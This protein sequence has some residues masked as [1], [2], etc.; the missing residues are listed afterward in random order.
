MNK[1]FILVVEDDRFQQMIIT[2]MVKKLVDLPVECVPDGLEALETVKKQ[3]PSLIICDLHM[4]KMDGV[5]FIYELSKQN[6]YPSICILSS[7]DLNIQSAVIEMANCYGIKHMV[8][9]KKPLTMEKLDS[10]IAALN[11]ESLHN[12]VVGNSSA[13]QF[14]KQEIT[15]A[16]ESGAIQ[17]YFQP[18]VEAGAGE[19]VS[20]EALVR[21][22]HPEYGLLTPFHFLNQVSEQ[23]MDYAV[24]QSMCNSALKF[25][26]TVRGLGGK[27][28]VS[29]NATPDDLMQEGLLEFILG[30]LSEYSLP[31]EY[32]T[33]EITETQA[34][35]EIGRLLHIA[36]KLRINGIQ[37]AIDDFGT[38][39]S[40]LSQLISSP[41]TE[42]K[43]DLSFVR[44]MLRS[45]KHSV[46]VRAST[47]IAKELGL[48]IV[49]E[50]V[51][52]KQQ[53]DYLSGLGCDLLQGYYY[54]K[55]VSS[56]SLIQLLRLDITS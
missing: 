8:S 48:K 28:T 35:T 12:K 41:F 31:A 21:W 13:Y 22:N 5:D 46:A 52:T 42:L 32:L 56:K 17:A 11:V 15:L 19:I 37:L 6:T 9:L 4:P 51:E 16:I 24:F 43:I 38:G 36:T 23:Q 30:M 47:L 7:M 53:A 10:A 44:E 18:Q 25:A 34:A 33:I 20:A 27:I 49:A 3:V 55:P 2:S 39:S 40:S 50:G 1:P 54:S 26:A 45:D 29:V 14:T